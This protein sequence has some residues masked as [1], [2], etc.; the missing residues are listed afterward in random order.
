MTPDQSVAHRQRREAV[1]ADYQLELDI[2]LALEGI[3]L[4]GMDMTSEQMARY[5]QIAREVRRGHPL[6]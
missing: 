3:P 1:Q 5:R 2:R 6:S 4:R